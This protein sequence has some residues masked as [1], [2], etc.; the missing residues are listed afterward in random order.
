MQHWTNTGTVNT[1]CCLQCSGR[2]FLP[3]LCFCPHPVTGGE[4]NHPGGSGCVPSA[5]QSQRDASCHRSPGATW[6]SCVLVAHYEW[7]P[8]HPRSAGTATLLQPMVK[9][10]CVGWHG[11]TATLMYMAPACPSTTL[12]V[13]PHFQCCDFPCGEWE[14]WGLI[15]R[16]KRESGPVG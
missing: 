9:H 11:D 6:V 4:R 15:P 8:P 2:Q 3:P 1:A 14:C 5:L 16:L 10:R 7:P 12:T 13:T